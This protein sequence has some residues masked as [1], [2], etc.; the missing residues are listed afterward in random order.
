MIL[1]DPPQPWTGQRS[2]YVILWHGCTSSDKEKI[3]AAGIDPTVGRPNPDFGRGF[4]TTTI[5]HQARQW[6]WK[7]FR[8]RHIRRRGKFQPVV[9]RFKVD[10]HKLSRLK[11]LGFIDGRYTN[12]DFWSFVQHCRTS[13]AEDIHD[14][15]GSVAEDGS[16]WY[17]V[18]SGPVAAFWEQRSTLH[19]ADQISFHTRK[20]AQVL[21]DLV[22]SGDREK[23]SWQSVVE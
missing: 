20:A 7:R 21:T 16:R 9:L 18:V 15:G 13:S 12:E 11:W 10:R 8:D 1:L 14:H 6:A 17:D 23:Y 19:D 2:R 5:E 3:E 22:R 4:Y